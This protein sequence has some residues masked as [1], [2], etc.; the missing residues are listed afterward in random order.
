MSMNSIPQTLSVSALEAALARS[1]KSEEKLRTIIDTIPTLAW[2]SPENGLGDFFSKP[3][4][5]YTGLSQEEARES[6]WVAAIHPDDLETLDTTWTK[7][8]ASGKEGE[9][10]ARLRRYDG[11]YRWFLFRAAPLRDHEGDEVV[12]Y[13]TNTD[14][15]D[16]KQAEVALRRSESILAEGE[17][18]SK[19]GSGSW[20]L[21]TGKMIWSAQNCRMLGLD[22]T[23]TEA[24][25][26]SFL[27]RLHPD[28]VV[29]V[30]EII[31]CETAARRPYSLEYRVVMPD[32]SIKHFHTL[33]RPVRKSSGEVDE[34]L[35]VSRD[36]TET[37]LAE[38]ALRRSEQ[39][40]RGQVEALVQTL[41]VLATAPVPGQLITRMLIT[42]ARILDAQWAALFLLD[43]QRDA[44]V[45]RAAIK[46][47]GSDPTYGQLPLVKDPRAWREDLSLR[48]LF[49]TGVPVICEDLDSDT[50][51]LPA[52]LEY[53]KSQGTKKF[54]RLPTLV[55][56]E[57]RGFVAIRHG[58]RGPYQP[59]EIEL[60]QA[61]A[62]Q[63][64]LA[65][66]TGETATL[67]ERN[68][69]AREIHDTLAQ[70]FT[71]VILQV[72][73]AEDA[74]A[75]GRRKESETHLHRAGELARW[76]LSEARRSVSALRPRA[77]EEDN[78]WDAFKKIVRN[79]TS[80]TTL[81]PTFHLEGTVPEL[82][83][84]YQENFLRIGQEALT[85]TIKHAGAR[86]FVTRLEC[87]SRDL[88]LELADDGD[89]FNLD[90]PHDGFGLMGM[91]ERVEQ[92][93][94]AMKVLSAPGK[95][96]QV[97]ITL[98]LISHPTS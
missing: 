32:G 21:R 56:G 12:W 78:F 8:R 38:D 55:G 22:P 71:G 41:D 94:G 79:I 97:R 36:V 43:E 37:K 24:S 81:E 33:M 30:R 75:S 25:V 31:D 59:W 26:E 35:G 96:T 91:R 40:A 14:I 16:L 13:G 3:W 62:H 5:E 46:G 82:P 76:G 42:M 50:R 95:G 34:Y 85:N 23:T 65:L 70:G 1:K 80:G 4:L 69:M 61:L 39:V 87:H 54:M 63:T 52:V 98:P 90:E 20:N 49:S 17:A 86:H 9:L 10:E 51:T 77:L 28:E 93:R 45:L 89:G 2:A 15:E 83:L 44:V 29:S 57:V 58:E 53:F 67:E 74:I 6:G 47:D 7:I 88:N 92:M 48:E 66:Q 73:A 18:I 64:M 19:T 72:E 11:V 84:A 68:R 60:A 27:E